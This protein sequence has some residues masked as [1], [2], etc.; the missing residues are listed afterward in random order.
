M[1]S[2]SLDLGELTEIIGPVLED[3]P[4]QEWR[5]LRTMSP[6]LAKRYGEALLR[7]NHR[8]FQVLQLL[9]MKE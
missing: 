3:I 9:Q 1:E 2:L 4:D 8:S 7:L 5:Q 6:A